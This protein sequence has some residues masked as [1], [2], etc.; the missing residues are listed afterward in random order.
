MSKS[1]ADRIGLQLSRHLIPISGISDV[2]TVEFCQ[3]CSVYISSRDADC[4][5]YAVCALLRI[6]E[7]LPAAALETSTWQLP[8]HVR[9]ADPS[10]NE[11]GEIDLLLGASIFFD[12][13]QPGQLK[14]DNHPTLQKTSF[15]LIVSGNIPPHS[16]KSNARR[17]LPCLAH[18]TSLN[19]QVER[20]WQQEEMKSVTVHTKEERL[21]EEH[22][23]K[24]IQR[25]ANGRFVMKL[26]VVDSYAGLSP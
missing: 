20:F 19:I 22:F 9:L 14:R 17:V 2:Q 6:V 16:V 8:K 4:G 12:V 21:C 25:N 24:A 15:G 10:F 11:T 7:P 23:A 26:P 1:L 18:N 3:V 13:L 5:S